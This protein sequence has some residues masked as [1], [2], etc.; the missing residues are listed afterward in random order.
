MGNKTQIR[1][2]PVDVVC[3]SLSHDICRYMK[4]CIEN[5]SVPYV[6][7]LPLPQDMN[8]INGRHLG[9][10]NKVLLELKAGSSGSKSLR[11]INGSDAAFMEL[12]LKDDST[13]PLLFLAN[14]KRN[15]SC[16][17]ET[18]VQTVYLLDQFSETSIFHALKYSRSDNGIASE[19]NSPVF[20]QKKIFAQNMIKNTSEYDTGISESFVRENKRKN[21]KRNTEVR[22][23]LKKLSSAYRNSAGR[24]E[25][26]RKF[27]FH[28]LNDYYIRQETGLNL[29]RKLSDE[30]KDELLSYL[31]ILSENSSSVLSKTLTE[32]FLYS[33]RMTHYGF[34]KDRLFTKEDLSKN[35]TV[36]APKAAA[37]EQQ[38][39]SISRNTG[40]IPEREFDIKPRHPSHRLNRC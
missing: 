30:Q 14:I 9:D 7:D 29:H 37:F 3:E 26:E 15:V 24:Y 25:K 39:V 21:I 36:K 28:A 31:E 11:W 4:E 17:S 13:E 2:Y 12:E 10:I 34:E 1:T 5:G 16:K 32:S 40:R 20:R 27:I 23:F 22:D 35:I 18:E 38:S 19:I 33:Q 8:V 6:Q